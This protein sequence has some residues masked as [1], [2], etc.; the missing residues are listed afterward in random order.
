[1]CGRERELTSTA[2]AAALISETYQNVDKTQCLVA[3]GVNDPLVE[4]ILQSLVTQGEIRGVNEKY[5]AT[6]N[7]LDEETL[8]IL[9]FGPHN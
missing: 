2:R 1:M 7:I 8:R 6:G 3:Q 9:E 4:D 5:G